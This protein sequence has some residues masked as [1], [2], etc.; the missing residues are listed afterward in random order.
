MSAVFAVGPGD[1]RM[2]LLFV[3]AALVAAEI[4]HLL[5]SQLA[6]VDLRALV[7]ARETQVPLVQEDL[8]GLTPSWGVSVLEV[9]LRDVEVRLS[10]SS[11]RFLP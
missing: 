11:A 6:D 8:R 2:T 10:S 5:R 1:G 3:A 4:A 7:E 9:E